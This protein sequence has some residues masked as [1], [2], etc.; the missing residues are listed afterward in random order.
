MRN[1]KKLEKGNLS[2][3]EDYNKSHSEKLFAK[4]KEYMKSD[5]M[6]D[7]YLFT[8]TFATSGSMNTMV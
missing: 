5:G 1:E 6:N 8:D 2:L 7:F 4:A 3:F